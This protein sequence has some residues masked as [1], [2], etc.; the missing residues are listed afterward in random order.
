MWR[1]DINLKYASSGTR[2]RDSY[3]L[4]KQDRGAKRMT[5]WLRTLMP[6]PM[7][8]KVSVELTPTSAA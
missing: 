5:R 3:E 6:I 8:L 1:W 4:N 7:G 2:S